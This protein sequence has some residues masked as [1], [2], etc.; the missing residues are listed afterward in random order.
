MLH[1]DREDN[2]RHVGDLGN[3][4]IEEVKDYGSLEFEDR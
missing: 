3:I 2:L 1:G 4:E